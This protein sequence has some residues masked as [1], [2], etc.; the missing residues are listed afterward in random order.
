MGICAR[1]REIK[2]LQNIKYKLIYQLRRYLS[3]TYKILMWQI[4]CSKYELL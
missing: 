4:E 3:I 1:V 2:V